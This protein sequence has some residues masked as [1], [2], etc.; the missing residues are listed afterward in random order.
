V[1]PGDV[2]LERLSIDYARDGA[3]EMQVM[4]RNA[5]S[6]DRLL[7]RLEEA[8]WLREVQPGPE[9]RESEVRSIVRGRWVGGGP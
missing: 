4:A 1:I 8:P 9:A 2:R 7:A 6:W 3:L 5:A